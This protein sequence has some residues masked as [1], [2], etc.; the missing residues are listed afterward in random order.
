MV[1]LQ[2]GVDKLNDLRVDY[3]IFLRRVELDGL[4]SL[5]GKIYEGFDEFE[6]RLKF[7]FLEKNF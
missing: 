6:I 1:L 5:D 3:F 7:L 2:R 4:L